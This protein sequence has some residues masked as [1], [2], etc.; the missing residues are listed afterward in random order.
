MYEKE[1]VLHV[2][3][4]RRSIFVENP[5]FLCKNGVKCMKKE[6]VLQLFRKSRSTFVQN[7]WI[8]TQNGVMCIK[9][10]GFTSI[11]F[12]VK[13]HWLFKQNCDFEG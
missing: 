12:L 4:E 6:L 1:L 8:L 5:W 10:T 7:H 13:I 3:R 2:F 11:P 9:S